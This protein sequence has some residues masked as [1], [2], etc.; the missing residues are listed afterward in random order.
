MSIP[1][2]PYLDNLS[3][4]EESCYSGSDVDVVVEV[5]GTTARGVKSAIEQVG[6]IGACHDGPREGI[7]AVVVGV[8]PTHVRCVDIHRHLVQQ[9]P[10]RTRVRTSAD[11]FGPHASTVAHRE[12]E[13]ERACHPDG[14]AGNVAEGSL[15]EKPGAGSSSAGCY[16]S[17]HSKEFAVIV[18]TG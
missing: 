1:S 5:D 17:D 14:I 6:C 11:G 15:I 12:R 2:Q 18:T 3:H 10:T 7:E 4:C 13:I 8:V 9:P 16:P